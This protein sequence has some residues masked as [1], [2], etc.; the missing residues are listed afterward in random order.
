[1]DDLKRPLLYV[2][3]PASLGLGDD[4]WRREKYILHNV[5]IIDQPHDLRNVASSF[6]L[7][8]ILVRVWS[9][10]SV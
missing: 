9:F 6:P 2:M 4:D 5:I 3:D 10:S 1:M 7:Y 8:F